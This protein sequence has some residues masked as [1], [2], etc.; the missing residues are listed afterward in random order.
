MKIKTAKNEIFDTDKMTDKDAEIHE[1][2]HNL[3]KVCKKYGVSSFTRVIFSR[4]K[5]LGAQTI[6]NNSKQL[7]DEYAFLIDTV[8]AWVEKTTGGRLRVVDTEQ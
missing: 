4:D 5:F 3:Q 7:N 8:C 2:I 1:A 6:P